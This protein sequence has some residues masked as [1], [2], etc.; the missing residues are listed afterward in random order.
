MEGL[1]TVRINDVDIVWL[2]ANYIDIDGTA[3]PDRFE[4]PD[5]GVNEAAAIRIVASTSPGDGLIIEGRPEQL[6]AI[7]RQVTRIAEQIIEATTRDP[8][9][10]R[11]YGVS[12]QFGTLP[13]DS[14][15]NPPAA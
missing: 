13:A 2:S 10:R 12:S 1:S 7:G 14:L 8:E 5:I 6:L 3:V 4:Y 15:T 11:M 9:L